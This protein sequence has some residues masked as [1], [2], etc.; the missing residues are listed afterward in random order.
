MGTV[1]SNSE[2]AGQCATSLYQA[3]TLVMGYSNASKDSDTTLAG[4]S[5]ASGKIDTEM[6]L[7][8]QVANS[9]QTF[10]EKIQKIDQ[11]FVNTDNSIAS[12][13]AGVDGWSLQSAQ[14]H[15]KQATNATAKKAE[16][17]KKAKAPKAPPR[18][19]SM[20]GAQTTMNSSSRFKAKK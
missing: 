4:N 15:V 13:L 10:S 17:K 9:V 12:T 2:V 1:Q 8:S 18:S 19:P 7:I 6:S 3:R 20:S 14:E 11:S 5:T 16:E